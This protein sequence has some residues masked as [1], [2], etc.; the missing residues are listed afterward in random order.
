VDP[1][2]KNQSEAPYY[3]NDYVLD[4]LNEKVAVL[5]KLKALLLQTRETVADLQRQLAATSAK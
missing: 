1:R 2:E 3:H 5:A 4:V